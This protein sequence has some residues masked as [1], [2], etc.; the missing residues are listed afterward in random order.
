MSKLVY[1]PF[2]QFYRYKGKNAQNIAGFV[3]DM[4]KQPTSFGQEVFQR[5]LMD[6][7][8]DKQLLLLM[9]GDINASMAGLSYSISRCRN[10][11]KKRD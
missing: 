8:V 1:V 10:L 9:M 11:S 5:R 6:N 4:S 3:N 7:E 2:G